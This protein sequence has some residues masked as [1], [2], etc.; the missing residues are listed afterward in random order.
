MKLFA[1]YPKDAH[2]HT[3]YY[4]DDVEFFMIWERPESDMEYEKRIASYEKG[5]ATR[6]AKE[7]AKKE[8]RRLEYE[9][10]KKEF[11]NE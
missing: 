7:A 2:I 10:L 6:E 4:Y 9:K 11:E 1:K 3:E 8:K 5:K